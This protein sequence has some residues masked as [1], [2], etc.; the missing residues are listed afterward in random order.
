M[1]V[2][3]SQSSSRYALINSVGRSR[4]VDRRSLEVKE[5]RALFDFFIFITGST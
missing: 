2:V 4:S 3:S 5:F 1:E